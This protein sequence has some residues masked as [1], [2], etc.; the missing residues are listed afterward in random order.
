MIDADKLNRQVRILMLHK[1]VKYAALVKR[2]NEK[3]G[4][5]KGIEN[6]ARKIR[7]G[8]IPHIEL[9]KVFDVLG[10]DFELVEREKE[11]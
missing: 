4:Y 11:V 10:Y 6:L 2:L 1:K 8:T 9:L 3:Y 7:R 5:D